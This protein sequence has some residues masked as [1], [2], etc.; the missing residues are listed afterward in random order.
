M[1]GPDQIDKRLYNLQMAKIRVL[2]EHTI[3]YVKKYRA[4]SE[5]YRHDR[6]IQPIVVDVCGFLAQRHIQ[7]RG[8]IR[9]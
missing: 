3:S 5:C 6:D 2:V 9:G 1:G 4:V 8:D 7:L